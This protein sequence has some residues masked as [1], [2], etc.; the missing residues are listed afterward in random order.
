VPD[1]PSSPTKAD[2]KIGADELEAAIDALLAEINATCTRFEN[3][4]GAEE[5]DDLAE[6]TRAMAAVAKP[7]EPQPGPEGTGEP[8]AAGD[9]ADAA[10][11]GAKQAAVDLLEQ[12]ADELMESLESGMASR[13]ESGTQ[14]AEPAE[15]APTDAASDSDAAGDAGATGDEPVAATPG[16]VP[17]TEPADAPEDLLASAVDQLLD[18]DAG[19]GAEAPPDGPT[20]APEAD[21]AAASAFADLD[22]ALD[23][24][25]DGTFESAAGEAVD[26]AGLDT[27]PDPA[28]MLDASD[29]RDAPGAEPSGASADPPPVP[30]GPADAPRT[31]DA[32][33]SSPPA[34]AAP[35]PAAAP[36]PSPS[37]ARGGRR[38]IADALTTMLVWAVPHLRAVREA[39]LA[40]AKPLGARVVIVLS[41]PLEGKPPSVRDSIGWVALWT[42]FLAVCV[43]ATLL[44]RSPQP[45]PARPDAS[46]MATPDAPTP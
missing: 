11:D 22:A 31:A 14:T 40:A 33:E 28:L 20:T 43:W 34:P 46:A 32:S 5:D 18:A 9:D 45:P 15:S 1:K 3:P 17:E 13:P 10:I 39:A 4:Q 2:P 19:D 7:A 42:L 27:R 8:T 12:A 25:L 23:E 44:L 29:A 36:A 38:R 6:Y 35:V 26:T 21:A 24:L 41:K 37:P 30:A 16:V